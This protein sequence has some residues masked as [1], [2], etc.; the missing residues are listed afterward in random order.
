VNNRDVIL[1][2]KLPQGRALKKGRFFVPGMIE[3]INTIT[4]YHMTEENLVGHV[5]EPVENYDLIDIVMICLGGGDTQSEENYSGVLKL[6]DVLFS[7]ETGADEKRRIL[8]RDFDIPM[9]QT[10]ERTVDVM[11]NFSKGVWEKGME[12]GREVGMKAGM[13]AGRKEGAAQNM[14]ESIRNLMESMG[15]PVEQAMSALKVPEADRPKYL[16]RLGGQ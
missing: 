8:Q 3:Y 14:L 16:E 6:L 2:K 13:E 15:W 5:K 9:T 10:L 12:A 11:C 4:R 1:D 7:A